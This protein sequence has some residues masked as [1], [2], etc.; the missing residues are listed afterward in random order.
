MMIIVDIKK[1][2]IV[3]IATLIGSQLSFTITNRFERDR[4]W[5][6]DCTPY[7]RESGK[8]FADTIRNSNLGIITYEGYS[9]TKEKVICCK[10]YSESKQ[11]SRLIES[12]IPDGF[13][14]H[15]QE[16]KS[17]INS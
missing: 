7:S 17:Y 5:I 10:I 2:A 9:S 1:A 6:F 13:Q 11:Q 8:Q 14:Y 4:V 3:S 12:L 16:I 15:I